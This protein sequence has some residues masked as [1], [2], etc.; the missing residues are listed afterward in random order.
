MVLPTSCKATGNLLVHRIFEIVHMSP[1]IHEVFECF[2]YPDGI[3]KF[4]KL[5]KEVPLRLHHRIED[6]VELAGQL[7]ILK[8]LYELFE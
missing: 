5:D 3:I 8:R 4:L 6:H 2:E 1:E 7:Q